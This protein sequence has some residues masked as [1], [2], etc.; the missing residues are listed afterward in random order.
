M[1]P[2]QI[3]FDLCIKNKLGEPCYENNKIIIQ[4]HEMSFGADEIQEWKRTEDFNEHMALATLHRW[5]EIPIIGSKLVSEHIECRSL[6]NPTKPGIEQGKLEMWI[7]MFPLGM[8]VP[9]PVNISPRMPKSYE[10]RVIIWNTSDVILVD[11]AIFGGE[12]TSDIYVKGWLTEDNKQQTDVHYRSSDGKG[13]FNWRF[14]FPFD[15]FS[16]ENCIVVKR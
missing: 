12:K 11:D 8:N 4:N 14:I 2:T 3:L 9:P 16:S 6:Y 7:D 1:K 15:Y 13:S 5:E 10:L